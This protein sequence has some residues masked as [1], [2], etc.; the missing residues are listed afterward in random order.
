M[1]MTLCLIPSI[2][3][4]TSISAPWSPSPRSCSWPKL[5]SQFRT[6][7]SSDKGTSRL[8]DNLGHFQVRPQSLNCSSS[9]WAVRESSIARASPMGIAGVSSWVGPADSPT[10]DA[11]CAVDEASGWLDLLPLP[12]FFDLG[13]TINGFSCIRWSIME[14]HPTSPSE[15]RQ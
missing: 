3:A 15:K 6:W 12:L 2:A 7:T 9:S 1:Q 11:S 8:V 13:G 5:I 14:S 10:K 4:P